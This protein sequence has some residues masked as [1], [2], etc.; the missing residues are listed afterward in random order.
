MNQADDEMSIWQTGDIVKI[1]CPKA[2]LANLPSSVPQ[3]RNF[4]TPG[5]DPLLIFTDISPAIFHIRNTYNRRL[6]APNLGWAGL[7]AQLNN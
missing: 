3:C 7:P 1:F 6:P 5:L 4:K 2:P